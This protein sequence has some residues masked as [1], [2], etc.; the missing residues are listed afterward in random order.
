MPPGN[1]PVVGFS[2]LQKFIL[3]AIGACCIVRTEFG[4]N[5]EMPTQIKNGTT[6]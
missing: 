6:S 2:A 1:P 3:A 4:Q 5:S